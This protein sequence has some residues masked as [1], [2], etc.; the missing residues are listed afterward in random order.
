MP[1]QFAMLASGSSGNAGL[2][3]IGNFGLL[4]DAGVGPRILSQRLS[5]V[6]ASWR[7]ISAV[8]LT[9]THGDHWKE[10]T[11]DH[12]LQREIPLFCHAVHESY[13]R[14]VSF[15][16]EKLASQG[17]VRNYEAGQEFPLGSRLRCQPLPLRHDDPATFGFRFDVPSDQDHAPRALGY[18]ADLG[19]WDNALVQAM[20]GLDVLALEF[21]HDVMMEQASNRSPQLIDRVLGDNGHLSND[22]A[23]SFLDAVL[24]YTGPE[25]L[26][27]LVQLHVSREC[28]QTK[29]AVQAARAVR[30]RHGARFL[31]HT[32]LQSQ[33]G[34][35]LTLRRLHPVASPP[36]ET[37]VGQIVN[38]PALAVIQPLFPGWE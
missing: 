38:L 4:I 32:A 17:L 26:Q 27:H 36:Y 34:P 22:Q 21:N 1:L 35:N 23:A 8:L 13:L 2:L 18:A 31:I 20:K 15:A 33:A 25:R 9:H 16:F 37:M 10:K 7:Q 14:L 11:F 5:A 19:C 30:A 6:G 24:R 28:N 12:L 3:Q 29:L